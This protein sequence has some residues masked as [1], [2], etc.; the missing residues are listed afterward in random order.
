MTA[1][2][3]FQPLVMELPTRLLEWRTWQFARSLSART[4]EARLATV[5][6]CAAWLEVD[7]E[8]LRAEQISAWLAQG[9]EWSDRTRWTYHGSLAAWFRWLVQQEYRADNPMDKVGSPR[10]PRSEPRPISDADMRRIL[11]TPMHRRTRAMILLAA[12]EG[13]RTHEIAKIKG[14]DLDLIAR[15]M[16]VKGKGGVTATMPLH[17]FVVEQAY[18]MPRRGYWFPGVDRGHQRRESVSGTIKEAM[19]RAGVAGSAHQLRH[20]FGTALVRAGVDLRTV[21]VLMRHQNLTSTAIYTAVADEQRINGIQTLDPFAI[22]E[23]SKGAQVAAPP[24]DLQAAL[25]KRAAELLELAESLRAA[26]V[27]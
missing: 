26:H 14:E 27:P 5:V 23:V 13:L 6:S 3:R 21:Q 24:D 15:T 20:W 17:H 7:P 25:R 16:V 12:F 2:M 1:T 8:F 22:T 4:V 9:G 19:V 10:R 18:R 11:R